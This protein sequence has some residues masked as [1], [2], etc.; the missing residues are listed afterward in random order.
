MEGIRLVYNPMRAR[1]RCQQVASTT[2][3]PTAD[4]VW[5]APPRGV[6]KINFD[7]SFK[8]ASRDGSFGVIAHDNEGNV[9]GVAAGR[10]EQVPD[11]FT[12]E[13]LAA[14]KAITW[15]KDMG[16]RY[17]QLEGDALMIIRKVTTSTM[18]LSPIGPYI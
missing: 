4:V 2:P 15:E 11:A 5:Q 9:L 14:L 17:I 10:L 3:K 16:F 6:I 1:L 8:V 12:A 18:D 13:C 7:G